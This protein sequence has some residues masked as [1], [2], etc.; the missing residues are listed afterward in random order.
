MKKTIVFDIDG[1]ISF[2]GETIG[3]EIIIAIENLIKRGNKVILASARPIRD[4]IPL[5][6]KYKV[7][8][9]LDLIGGNGTIVRINQ[10]IKCEEILESDVK[11]II[12]IAEEIDNKLLIDGDWNYYYNGPKNIELYNR[13]SSCITAKNVPYTE[14]SKVIKMIVLTKNIS[15]LKL[16]CLEQ[17]YHINCYDEEEMIDILPVNVNKYLSLKK[18]FKINSYIAFGNDVND[19]EL[20]DNAERAFIVGDKLKQKNFIRIRKNEVT[21]YINSIK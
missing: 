14:L 8:N 12:K 21:N 6:S 4:M 15:D 19:I 16:E 18:Y 9:D 2:D 7:L 13:I 20:L 17:K 1:T 11:K 5:I 10:Q 3:Q